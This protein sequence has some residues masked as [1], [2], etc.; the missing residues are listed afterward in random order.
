MY[1]LAA[2]GAGESLLIPLTTGGST[3]SVTVELVYFEQREA[4]S[5]LGRLQ[6][7]GPRLDVPTTIANWAVFSPREVTFLRVRGNLAQGRS[8]VEFMED[9]FEPVIA[10]AALRGGS[11][12]GQLDQ[13]RISSSESS[14]MGRESEALEARTE[15]A[16]DEKRGD[17]FGD[18]L[19]PVSRVLGTTKGRL[20]GAE[21]PVA[22]EA[23]PLRNNAQDEEDK[24]ALLQ[25]GFQLQESGI[26]PLK[27]RMPKS[28][29]AHHFSRLMT[30]QE[31]LTLEA[32]FVHLPMPWIPF[33]GMGLVLLPLGGIVA[34]RI[35]RV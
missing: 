3:A 32:T 18:A 1:V 35:R 5:R 16:A 13:A 10:V 24:D 4:L 20:R 8:P 34:R 11:W 2:Q 21:S 28:G 15:M 12:R 14:D 27:I 9:P 23:A 26:L 22:M 29:T 19:K 7:E 31:A 17:G 30:S 25:L 6:L 33:A